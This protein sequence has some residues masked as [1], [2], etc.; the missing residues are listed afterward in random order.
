MSRN[1]PPPA[2]TDTEIRTA[3]STMA[4][5][6]AKR[7]QTRIA[8]EMLLAQPDGPSVLGQLVG[9]RSGSRYGLPLYLA[10]LA[11]AKAPRE[12]SYTVQMHPLG[13]AQMLGLRPKQ[14]GDPRVDPVRQ[15]SDTLTRLAKVGLLER[16]PLPDGRRTGPRAIRLLDPFKPGTDY[17]EP[18]RSGEYIVLRRQFWETG[19]HVA[20]SP[21]ALMMLL[22]SLREDGWKNGYPTDDQPPAGDDY[23]WVSPLVADTKYGLHE[24]T[25]SRGWQELVT[26]ELLDLRRKPVHN[27]FESVRTRNTYRV[28]YP[29]LHTAPPLDGPT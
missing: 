17:Q 7:G 2:Q 29:R 9:G 27:D 26:R 12:G 5:V 1:S 21:R 11:A 14:P 4:E 15:V 23:W 13:Y 20:L 24:D 3:G 19:W 25:R 8:Q 28:N 10:L 18:T 22:I 6:V 16:L